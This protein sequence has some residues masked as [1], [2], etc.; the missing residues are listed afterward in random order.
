MR[1]P[2]PS[3]SCDR[4]AWPA[5]TPSQC[6]HSCG[7]GRRPPSLLCTVGLR[8]SSCAHPGITRV[9]AGSGGASARGPGPEL[10]NLAKA[11]CILGS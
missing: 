9:P 10:T 8:P 11:G 5:W 4:P 6:F 3:L 2:K 1:G 7:L